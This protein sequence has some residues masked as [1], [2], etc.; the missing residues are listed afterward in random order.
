MCYEGIF[1]EAG[2]IAHARLKRAQGIRGTA[3]EHDA[4]EKDALA[5]LFIFL[6]D[7]CSR[8]EIDLE[9]QANC[10]GQEPSNTLAAICGR[11][12]EIYSNIC[13]E[14]ATAFRW[15]AQYVG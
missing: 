15:L 1:E 6:C 12:P 11:V 7:Y 2:E 4:A 3:A 5:D 14:E 8:S 10:Y 9:E 13:K